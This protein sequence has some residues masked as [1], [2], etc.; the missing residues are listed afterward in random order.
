ME[1]EQQGQLFMVILNFCDPFINNFCAKP[2]RVMLKSITLKPPSSIPETDPNYAVQNTL[3][4]LIN[5]P[6]FRGKL[7]LPFGRSFLQLLL[8]FLK[9]CNNLQ[10]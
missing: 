10:F 6:H 9:Y 4:S 2:L 5:F 3:A 7:H 1:E 8:A